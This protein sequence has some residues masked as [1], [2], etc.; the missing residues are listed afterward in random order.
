VARET[1]IPRTAVSHRT[2]LRFL[3][4]GLQEL[5]LDDLASCFVEAKELMIPLLVS[6]ADESRRRFIRNRQATVLDD[7]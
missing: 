5:G 3:E 2:L 4:V 1:P 7:A 6:S